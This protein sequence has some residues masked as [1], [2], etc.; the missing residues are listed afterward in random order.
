MDILHVK[1]MDSIMGSS[2]YS[3]ICVCCGKVFWHNA[4]YVYKRGIG[5]KG[6]SIQLF[7]CSYG[8]M[9]EWDRLYDKYTEECGKIR[10]NKIRLKSLMKKIKHTRDPEEIQLLI[11]HIENRIRET[12]E[13]NKEYEKRI[14]DAICTTQRHA[15]ERDG[16]EGLEEDSEF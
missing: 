13:S 6:T 11:D 15:R 2:P 1:T 16:K 4:E 10:R 7:F 9:R 8:H 3:K 14:E 5:Y 12:E